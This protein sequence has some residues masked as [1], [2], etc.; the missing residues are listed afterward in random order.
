MTATLY[1]NKGFSVVTG[2]TYDTHTTSQIATTNAVYN[3]PVVATSGGVSLAPGCIAIGGRL[4]PAL[5]TSFEPYRREAFRHRTIPAQR[6]SINYEN[7]AG[8]GTLNTEGLWRRDQVDWSYGAGQQFLDRKAESQA[9]RYYTSKGVNPWVENQLTLLNDTTKQYSSSSSTIK[10]V[11]VGPYVYIMDGSAIEYVSA[12]GTT[13]TITA[14]SGGWGTINDICTDGSYV[15]IATSNG[16]W[17]IDSTA[18]TP[19]ATN[20]CTTGAISNNT[21]VITGNSWSSSSNTITNSGGFPNVTVGAAITGTN[22]ASNTHVTDISVTGTSISISRP[23]T[24]TGSSTTITVTES[25]SYTIS[26][27]TRVWVANNTVLAAAKQSSGAANCLLAFTYQP[28]TNAAPNGENVLMVH[29]NPNFTWTCCAGGETQIYVGGAILNGSQVPHGIIYRA[30]MT[31]AVAG[32]NNVNQPFSLNYPIQT[33]PMSVGEYP[34]CLYAY[35]N[36][37]MIGTNLGCRMAQTL[38]VYDPNASATGD[39]KSGPLAPS[40]VGPQVSLPVNG[41]V[42]DGRFIYWTFSNYDSTSSGLYRMDLTTFVNGDPLAP[43]YASDLMVTTS[44][45]LNW[46]DIDPITGT[47]LISVA[48]TG[49]YTAASTYVASGTINSGFITYGIVD[50]KTPVFLDISAG[51]INGTQVGATLELFQP[52]NES[53]NI[54]ALGDYTA[55]STSN[56]LT[57]PTGYSSELQNVVITL[58]SNSAKTA[59]P[60]L[61]RYSLRSWPKVRTELDI[62]PVIQLFGINLANST[63]VYADPYEA[64][65]YLQSLVDNQTIV[66]Y[67]EG[68]ATANVV[69]TGIDWLPHKRADNAENGYVGD[70]VVSLTTIGGISYT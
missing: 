13:T 17:S 20:Y 49:V 58:T 44:D 27:F 30:S 16:I 69:V 8:Y 21:F 24:G 12:W 1:P 67:Q 18:G 28:V 32:I 48:S 5:D 43:V 46:V 25:A 11:A 7:I 29:P 15:Y 41:I 9:S 36:Y 42:G 6:S 22:I 68:P 23:T 39:L 55:T 14:P 57:V 56:T 51:V 61:Y 33:L 65:T 47:P 62:T 26:S 60:T 66:Q 59:T 40:L 35:L 63:E 34:T 53:Y 31:G 52:S 3:P 54:L 64:L 70:V 37:I 45:A 38:S 10:A 19:S 2:P 50:Q 4:F